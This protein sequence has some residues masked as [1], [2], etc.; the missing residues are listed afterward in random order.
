[1]SAQAQRHELGLTLGRVVSTKQTAGST[2]LDLRSGTALQANYGFRLVG[3]DAAALL[4]GVHF[5][6]SPLRE[7]NS[8]NTLVTKDFASLYLTPHITVKLAPNSRI[9][10][11][12]TVGGGYA[13]Y[14]HSTARL[15]GEPNPAPRLL[16]R[17]AFVFGGGL[18]VRVVSWLSL[19]GEVRD[20]Y[21]G[22]PQFNIPLS[23][24]Q[25]NVVAGGGFVLR[26]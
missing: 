14:E 10:P 13:L 1:M 6:A 15:D 20:F 16:H 7:V 2:S 4:I 18:D 23:G 25:H 12:G 9:S 5:L 21:T 11:W 8:L 22:A 17:G 3:N 26:F 19:R 24:G